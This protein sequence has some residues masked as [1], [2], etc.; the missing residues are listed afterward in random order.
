MLQ[1]PGKLRVGLEAEDLRTKP[2][3][4][5]ARAKLPGKVEACFLK[6]HATNS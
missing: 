5:R 2:G 1:F 4:G 3:G 6:L